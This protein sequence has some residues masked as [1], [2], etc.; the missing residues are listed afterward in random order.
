MLKRIL[1][2][3]TTALLAVGLT[4]GVALPASAHTPTVSATCSTL[5][6]KMASYGSSTNK[7]TVTIDDTVVENTTFGDSFAQKTYSFSGAV[8][9]NYVVEIDAQDNTYDRLVSKGTAITGTTTPC[10]T[11]TCTNPLTGLNNFTIVTEK[12]LT[13]SNGGAHVEGTAAVGSDLIVNNQ[14]HVQNNHDGT[15][16]PVVDGKS[17][18]LLVGGKVTLNATGEAFQVNNGATRIGT[19]TGGSTDGSRFYTTAAKDRWIRMAG[20][21]TLSDVTASGLFASTFPNLFADLR[22]S[23]SAIGSYNSGDVNFVT[24][25]ANGG[26]GQKVT[27]SAGV[28]NVLRVNASQL[29]AITKLWFDGGV[30]PSSST[31]FIIDIT[32]GSITATAPVLMNIDAHYVLW[33]F[34]GSTLNISTA[35]FIKGSVLAPNAQLNL[36]SGGIEGQIA[37]KSMVITSGAEIHHIGYTPCVTPP[38]TVTVTTAPSATPPTCTADGSLVIPTQAN[39]AFSGGTNGAGPGSYTVTAAG[40]NGYTI[41]GTSSW[42]LVVKAKGDGVNCEKATEPTLTVAT[43][44]ATTGNVVSASV[45]IPNLANLSYTI[46]GVNGGARLTPGSNVPLAAGNYTVDVAAL[47]GYTNTGPSSFPVNIAAFDC[48]KAVAP[49]LTVAQ[50]DLSTAS[51]TPAFITIPTTTPGLTYTIAGVN[52]G[53]PLS[54]DVPLAAGSYTVVVTALTGYTNTGASSFPVVVSSLSCEQAV[55][56]ALTVAYCHPTSGVF[57]S[58]YLTI[59]TTTPGLEYR[60]AGVNGGN[61]LTPG[62]TVDVAAGTTT[63]LVTEK[64]GVTNTGPSS[65]SV[66][67][68]A[69][70]CEQAIIPA[71][72]AA[73]CDSTSGDFVPASVTI[74]SATPGLEYRIAGVNSGNPLPAGSTWDLPAGTHT[75]TVTEKTGVTNVGATS[76]TIVVDELSCQEAQKPTLTIAECDDDGKL[77]SAYLVATTTTP[78]LTYTIRGGAVL[79]PGVETPVNPGTYTV[80]VTTAS[81]VTNTGPSS[82][83]I[84]VDEFDCNESVEPALTL[85]QCDA[86]TGPRSGFVTIPTTTPGLVYSIGGVD[87]AAGD[88]VE[89]P[90]GPYTVDVRAKDG[91]TNTGKSSFSGVVPEVD[92]EG[93]DY[94]EPTVTP[95]SCD[96]DLGG[97]KNGSLLFTLNPDLAYELDGKPVITALVSD[98][99]AGAHTITV[100]PAAGHYITGGTD[101]FT[102]TVPAAVDCDGVY[103]TPLDP[104][105]DPETCD[106]LSDDA[107]SL[108]GS[109]TIV[110]VVGIQ[111]YIGTKAD[112]SDKVA[113]GTAASVGNAKYAYPAGSYYV[114]AESQDPSITIKPGHTVWP[115]TVSVPTP[116]CVPTLGLL[117]A[118]ATAAPAVCDAYG[119][120]RGTITILPT[121]GV[122]Y[123]IQGG[124]ALTSTTTKVAPGTYTVVATATVPGSTLTADTWVLTVGATSALCDLTTLAFTGQNLGGYLLVAAIL[125]Q[126]GLA[127]VALQFARSRRLGRHRLG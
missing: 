16:Q 6:V 93:E 90:A 32:G 44:D 59:P 87:Y 96:T 126:V 35:E 52:G 73:E 29:S 47:N 102:V 15:P 118:D 91:Y 41:T 5:T 68:P 115:L 80:D 11:A 81:G 55:Q 8:A 33:N 66:V 51:L 85:A 54:G 39:V 108:A 111:W 67:V 21:A 69:L 31:P 22:A 83:T 113:V 125:F 95:Q 1:A 30:V 43:C 26:D 114:F 117:E 122:A 27:L 4:V 37:A 58:A 101:T 60:I 98:V 45:T 123:A 75:V 104:F 121:P 65:F 110:H 48:N 46:A 89:L 12:T 9:H 100:I 72:T 106:P 20:S 7:L 76:F 92:C 119:D 49:A 77:V 70:S 84:T 3:L 94:V 53:L 13:V 116:A 109:I 112:G 74:T 124:P 18:G 88:E 10:T 17:T 120:A 56:P 78:G 36:T 23:S 63:V 82:F 103:T 107:A 40:T 42:T 50:C 105:A 14:Y 19:T 86:I 127:L 64:P 99:T 61:P 71:L 25:T 28:V 34:A 57:Q 2:V 79:Q 24:T 62:S 38:K 97:V